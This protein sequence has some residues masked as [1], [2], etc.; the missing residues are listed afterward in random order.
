MATTDEN[1]VGGYIS[2]HLAPDVKRRSAANA[3]AV[4]PAGHI[5]S[6]VRYLR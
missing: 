2:S 5:F 4:K 1:A 3:A 6:G